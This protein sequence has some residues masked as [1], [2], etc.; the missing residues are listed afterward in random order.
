MN[1]LINL[2]FII[3]FFINT[4]PLNSCSEEV[5]IINESEKINDI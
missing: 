3:L 5:L 4:I 2:M 1:K